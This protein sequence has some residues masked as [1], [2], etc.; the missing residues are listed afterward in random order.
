MPTEEFEEVLEFWF[1]QQLEHRSCGDGP[2]IRMVVSRGSRCGHRRTISPP[3]GASCARGTR[4]LV[5]RRRDLAS[6]SSSSS[7]SSPDRSIGARRG[8]L[9]RI[10]R[11]SR[12]RCQGIEIG[13]Y[14]ALETPWEKTF[15]FLPFGHS[16][17]LTHVEVGGQACR[18]ARGSG[19]SGA[20]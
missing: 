4:P 5:A 18:G 13:H 2:P 10:G 19:A 17:E 3:T 8:R 16:E 15:F 11:L 7:I 6:R 14:A 1:P 20:A 9:R 12:W